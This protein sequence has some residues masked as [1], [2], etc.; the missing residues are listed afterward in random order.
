MAKLDSALALTATTDTTRGMLSAELSTV[1][2]FKGDMHQALHYAR[3]ATQLCKGKVD[4]DVFAVLCGNTSI[5]YR[6]LG[7][8]DSAL[9]CYRQGIEEAQKEDNAANLAYLYNNMSVLYMEMGRNAEGIAYARKAQHEARRAGD[10]T[11]LCSA[12]ANEG[13]GNVKNGNIEKGKVILEETWRKAET[14]NSTPLKLKTINYLLAALRTTGSKAEQDYYLAKGE[15]LAASLSKES[16]AAAGIHESKMNL[17]W[18]RK[19]YRG[20]LVAAKEIEAIKGQQAVP[21]YLLK[22]MQAQCYAAMGNHEMAYEAEVEAM[23]LDDSLRNIDVE[24]QLSEY[25]VRLK[26]GEKQMEI[27]RLT[28]ENNAWRARLF[29]TLAVAI[30]LMALIVI[31]VIVYRHRHKLRIQR[32]RIDKARRY[33]E[34]L[35]TERSRMARDLHDGACNDLLS[36]G[37][38]LRQGGVDSDKAAEQVALLR[39]Q[40]RRISHELMPPSFSHCTLEE[41]LNDFF[42][43]VAKPESLHIGFT[44][45]GKKWDELPDYKA[46]QFYRIIQEATANV[47]R[48]AGATEMIVSMQQTDAGT[49]CLEID[50]NGQP[51]VGRTQTTGGISSMRDRAESM[52]YTFSWWQDDTGTHIRVKGD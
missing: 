25:S 1:Y 8:N 27:T 41:I 16:I 12:L 18:H 10:E 11:E 45:T 49:I 47:I 40:L 13:I 26:T 14:M 48:H 9:V 36:L 5:I 28:A 35:E 52:G 19:D 32:E 20:A 31:L 21:P 43:H 50:D 4:S 15:Q 17:L 42:R 34:G 38:L 6:R 44:L 30:L 46:Y 51:T 22:S 29:A 3:Q 24:R 7:M 23:R 2:I 33:I 39:E 37:M